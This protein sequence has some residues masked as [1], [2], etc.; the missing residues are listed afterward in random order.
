MPETTVPPKEVAAAVAEGVAEGVTPNN[1]P[2]C[3]RFCRS[4]PKRLPAK[5][6]VVFVVAFVEE[7]VVFVV[8]AFVSVRGVRTRRQSSGA[9]AL[10]RR[11]RRLQ[12][13]ICGGGGVG[14]DADV[15]WGL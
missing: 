7:F 14:G 9:T 5:S 1:I 3:P 4:T 11:C 8:E 10:R 6:F 2:P 13:I 15:R 12:T